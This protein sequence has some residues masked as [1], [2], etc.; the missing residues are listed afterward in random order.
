MVIARAESFGLAQ[1]H[2]LRGRVGRGSAAS[3]CLLMYQPPLSEGGRRR[4]ETMRATEDGFRISEV[5][6]EMR[7]A[8]D[9]IGTAQSGLPRFRVADLESQAALMAVAQ[10]DARKLLA[11]DPGLASPRGQAARVLL[12]LMERDQAIRLISVG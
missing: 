6:L 3:T 10:S 11:D 5:D 7:G 4:L 1:V 12:W 9:L 2:Q 8:G